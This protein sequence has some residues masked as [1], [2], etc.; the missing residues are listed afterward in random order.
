MPTLWF[1][2]T[3]SWFPDQEK[4][5]LKV[6]KSDGEF[7][8][9]EASDPKLGERWLYCEGT[10]E[11]L[12]TE[13]ETNFERLFG[14]SNASPYV[15]DGI[16]DYLIHDRFEAINSNQIGT[17]VC[18]H[19]VLSISAGETKT[20]R[21]RLSDSA[22]LTQPFGAEFDTIR[23]NRIKEADEFYQ[24]ISPFPQSEDERNVQRQ[25]FAGMLWTKQFYY[26]VV[27]DWLKGD[28]TTPPPPPERMNGRNHEWIHLYNDDVLSMPDKWEFPWF[29]VWDLAFHVIPLAMLDPD[30]AKRQLSATDARMVYASQRAATS[31]R[32]GIE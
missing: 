1:R 2:N 22:N 8:V 25:A 17:K 28:R 13:N 12:F 11:L 5:F 31:L 29:T 19:Y 24:R 9:I 20:I 23:H 3:W 10:T 16:N 15:K 4:P 14:V 26:Y 7:S 27:E 18:T 21:L 30:F 6:I 32:M